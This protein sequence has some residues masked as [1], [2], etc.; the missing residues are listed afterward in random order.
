MYLE[1]LVRLTAQYT[2]T[3]AQLPAEGSVYTGEAKALFDRLAREINE[4]IGVVA[5]QW[6]SFTQ[7]AYLKTDKD[8][9]IGIA[10]LQANLARIRSICDGSDLAQSRTNG[11]K[12]R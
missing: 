5:R 11:A 9:N 12:L 6:C 2:E 1:Q 3:L 8:R 4:A 7:I 10:Q